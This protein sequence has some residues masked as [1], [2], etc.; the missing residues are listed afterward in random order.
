KVMRRLLVVPPSKSVLALLREMRD[1]RIHMAL[2]V[3]EYGGLD[4]LVTIEDLVEQIVGEI[5]DEHD[6]SAAAM[7]IRRADGVFEALGRCPIED[8]EEQLGRELTD[9]EE[10][11]DEV[12]TVGGLIIAHTGRVS[13]RG[14]VIEHPASLAFE[15]VDADP[16]RIKRVRIRLRPQQPSVDA[17]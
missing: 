1:T 3:D 9:P 11:D 15:I 7:L 2:I 12:D 8:L 13:Q 17:A 16:R 14:E 5:D 4:G 10:D 6:E